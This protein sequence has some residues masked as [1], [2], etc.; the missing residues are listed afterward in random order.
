MGNCNVL[1]LY[2]FRSKQEFIYRTNKMREITGASE[3]IAGLFGVFLDNTKLGIDA[4]WRENDGKPLPW[5][6][7]PEDRDGSVV[8]EGGGNLCVLFQNEE[9]YIAA[10][11]EFSRL[12]L[13]EAPG[14]GLIA[15]CAPVT[16]DF[17]KDLAALHR[18]HDIVKNTGANTDFCN[19]LPY[20]QI[21]RKSFQPLVEKR[22][23]NHGGI[24]ELTAE[25]AKKLDAYAA[26]SKNDERWKKEGMYIDELVDDKGRDSLIAVIYCDGNSIGNKLKGIITEDNMREFA[27]SIHEVLVEKPLEA[28]HATLNREYGD[29]PAR[30]QFRT[31]IDHGDEITIVANA[32]VALDIV[33][34][35]FETVKEGGYTACAGIAVCHSHDPFSEV[36]KISEECCESGKKKN[37]GAILDG[38]D[39]ASYF[40]F[41]FCRSGITGT[42]DQIREAQEAT[43]TARPYAYR[44]P[45]VLDLNDFKETGRLLLNSKISRGDIKNLGNLILNS[46][47]GQESDS[48]FKLEKERLKA[49]EEG[50]N[51]LELIEQL[52]ENKG[53]FKQLLFDVSSFYDVWFND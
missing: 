22:P 12:V 15:A 38:K 48:R 13:K 23:S 52:A 51:N 35:Y 3:L 11:K 20:T 5:N 33:E 4:K 9:A 47:A 14:L 25:S 44:S 24:D 16:G 49:K 27:A 45:D 31:V 6:G 43:H 42:L 32:H 40:D 28:I 10:N 19:T 29:D 36:Y 53:D 41:H 26:K 1:A 50:A 34:T 2:G 21:D 30:T 17:K 37:R 18:A 7:L 39:E 46:P 8:Y